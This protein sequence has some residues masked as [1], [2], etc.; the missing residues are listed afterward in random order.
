M[1]GL[2]ISGLASG[3]DTE[4]L[5][6]Q[7]MELERTP[8]KRLQQR[9]STLQIQKGAWHDLYTRL[10]TLQSK[11][12]EL[13][14]AYTFNSYKATSSNP[15]V[16]TAS[17]GSGATAGSYHVGIIQ[18]AQAH[19]VAGAKY[20][21]VTEPLG[22][23]GTFYIT[24]ASKTRYV[25]ISNTD[26]LQNIK[27]LIN[28]V[29]PEGGT[30]P[31]AGDIVTATIVDN[32]LIITSK[33][34]GEA[35]EISFSDPDHILE[36]LGLVDST[37]NILSE[38]NI[39]APQDAKFTIDGITVTRST[40]SVSDAIPGVTLNL[41]GITDKNYNGIIESGETINL[42]VSRDTQRAVDAIQAFVNQYNSVMDF[43]STKIGKGGDLQGD[44]TLA[45]IQQTLWKMVTEI[46]EGTSGKYRTLWDIGISTGSVVGS[47]T[48]TFDR[49][50][51]LTLDT[52]KLTAALEDDPEAVLALFENIA[53]KG[54]AE[55]LDTY[56]NALV[57]S[58]DGILTTKEQ[59][60][61][62]IMDDL[63]EQINRLE[64][65][66]AAKEEQL[67]KQFA[68]MEKALSMLQSQGAWLSSQIM[69]LNAY[70]SAARK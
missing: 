16:L 51:K 26:S 17:T 6:K 36:N 46:V 11:L 33:T 59:S 25:T 43:I 8:V 60:L 23:S 5:I 50:G 69:G 61:Q 1:A 67:K 55:K 27:N 40:N 63:E 65:R 45:R 62:D 12:S 54:V 41:L 57:R 38:A 2:Y 22:L 66:L 30:G 32:R 31:G 7:L 56:I 20:S 52:S 53:D 28:T 3:L 34:I 49:S 24:V 39:Q 37:G 42:Q 18:L 64:E 14:L 15:D 10:S 35:G 21:S 9:K 68:A 47:G 4:L 48:L 44:P 19:K 58:G 70:S 29:T 13:K